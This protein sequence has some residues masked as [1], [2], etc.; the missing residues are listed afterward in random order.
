MTRNRYIGRTFIQPS[1]HLRKI[2]VLKK[3]GFLKENFCGK[4]VILIDDSIVRGNTVAPLVTELKRFGAK[5]VINV[6]ILGL[7]YYLTGSLTHCFS[8]N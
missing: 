3:F 6:K 7:V 1:K 5:E 4:R 2:G 8:S